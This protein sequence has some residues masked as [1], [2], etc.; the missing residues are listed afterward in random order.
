[1]T[2][3]FTAIALAIALEGVLYAAFPEAM[4]K[5]L[6]QILGQP[7]NVLRRTGVM[8]VIAGVICVWLLRR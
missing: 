3:F 4:K 1:M 8:A 5:F 2:D 7:D 6:V